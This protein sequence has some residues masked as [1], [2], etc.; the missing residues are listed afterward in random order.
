MSTWRAGLASLSR[1]P[2]LRNVAALAGGTAAAQ[3]VTM[4]A[5]PF[6]TRLYGPEAFG[7]QGVFMSLLSI[8]LPLAGLTYPVAI[9]LASDDD[10][11]RDI[12]SVSWII[13]LVIALI[14]LTLLLLFSE[15]AV[16]ILQLEGI[17]W[18][19]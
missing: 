13:S 3:A 1:K 11:A 12:E 14:V 4:A 17:G 18:A 16:K 15:A 2:F 7:V 6:V 10:E 9:V 19:L 5:A 8:A